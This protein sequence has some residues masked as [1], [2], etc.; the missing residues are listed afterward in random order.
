MTLLNDI[1]HSEP[2]SPAN[3]CSPSCEGFAP[4][5]AAKKAQSKANRKALE[6]VKRDCGLVKGKDSMGRTI[7]E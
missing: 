1:R 7:W 6:Q 5:Q 3:P 4:T 2:H